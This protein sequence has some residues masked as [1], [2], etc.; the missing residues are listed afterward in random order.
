MVFTRQE[1]IKTLWI[2]VFAIIALGFL[3]GIIP[4]FF[5][6]PFGLESLGNVVTFTLAV[7]IGAFFADMVMK[8]RR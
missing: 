6:L 7:M 2:S 5:D 8:R 3:G 4:A 1:F